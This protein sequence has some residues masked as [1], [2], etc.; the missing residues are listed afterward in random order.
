MEDY[1]SISTFGQT[2]TMVNMHHCLC[3]TPSVHSLKD[4]VRAMLALSRDS[5]KSE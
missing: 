5:D 3:R 2:T 1:P 4:E